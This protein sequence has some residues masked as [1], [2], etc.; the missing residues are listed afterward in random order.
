MK[1]KDA[2]KPVSEAF[3]VA[4]EAGANLDARWRAENEADRLL[5]YT[6]LA[7]YEFKGCGRHRTCYAKPKSKYVLKIPRN[8]AGF[9]ANRAEVAFYENRKQFTDSQDRM[10]RCRLVMIHDIPCVVME[11]IN[12]DLGYGPNPWPNWVY[13]VDCQQVGFDRKGRLVAYDFADARP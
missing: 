12:R 7:G 5:S 1:V 2:L 10:A 6:L 13:T 11:K 4:R 8:L 9:E 3:A